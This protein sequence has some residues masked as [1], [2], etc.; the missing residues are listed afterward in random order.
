MLE[1]LDSPLIRSII[2]KVSSILTIIIIALHLA[3]LTSFLIPVPQNVLGGLL[4]TGIVIS[5][6]T[7][8]NIYAIYSTIL[9]FL[10]MPVF[11]T[12]EEIDEKSFAIVIMDIVMTVCM[13]ILCLFSLFWLN[14]FLRLLIWLPV[15]HNH[16]WFLNWSRNPIDNRSHNTNTRNENKRGDVSTAISDSEVTPRSIELKASLMGLLDILNYRA[17]ALALTPLQISEMTFRFENYLNTVTLNAPRRSVD[18]RTM[19]KSLLVLHAHYTARRWQCAYDEF[20][21][22]VAILHLTEEKA[23]LFRPGSIATR[24][25]QNVFLPYWLKQ[26]DEAFNQLSNLLGRVRSRHAHH[27]PHTDSTAADAA[28]TP[29]RE[30]YT[31]TCSTDS[32]GSQ[33]EDYDSGIS[34]PAY[35]SLTSLL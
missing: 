35:S 30:R 6:P 27:R 13:S 2:F 31:S 32:H 12:S 21:R 7:F 19:D 8:A 33:Q 28:P 26:S 10:Y 17:L 1:R 34:S 22:L 11:R 18:H 20:E 5:I 9:A 4:I 3:G 15:I 25:Y 14:I 23:G 24:Y 16:K 29:L